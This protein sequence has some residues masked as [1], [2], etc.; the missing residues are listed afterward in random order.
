MET[1]KPGLML[2]G[3]ICL[4]LAA[5]IVGYN[6]PHTPPDPV[7]EWT[8]GKG[9]TVNG[10]HV[11]VDAL[12][13]KFEPPGPKKPDGK[14]K[15]GDVGDMGPAANLQRNIK[16]ENIVRNC[17]SSIDGSGLCVPACLE[18]MALSSGY[19]EM[20]GFVDHAKS[21]PGG[22]WPEKTRK[23]FDCFVAHKQGFG[24]V[25]FQ[26]VIKDA[27]ERG[28]RLDDIDKAFENHGLVMIAYDGQIPGHYNNHRVCTALIINGYHRGTGLYSCMDTNYPE[29]TMSIDFDMVKAGTEWYAYFTSLNP[30][31]AP[32]AY[33]IVDQDP[34]QLNGPHMVNVIAKLD[35][36][37]KTCP[38]SPSCDCG[39]CACHLMKPAAF[40][41]VEQRGGGPKSPEL[42][43][44][45][46][47]VSILKDFKE[48]I[49][50]SNGKPGLRDDIAGGL[51]DFNKSLETRLIV[52][53][54]VVGCWMLW[55]GVSLHK[56][57]NKA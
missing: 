16:R 10:K 24:G 47:L 35:E 57:A 36:K 50:G 37:Q 15:S 55:V 43:G 6:L 25:S 39:S 54:G 17:G 28:F 32:T 12:R 11:D 8:L 40:Q 19:S 21:L 34:L 27:K 2:L 20:K 46:S 31:S 3:V 38:C 5:G 56:L 33:L 23:Q 52:V 30:P 53:G 1:K 22:H 14:K 44:I 42:F 18:T 45:E 13:L 26:L 41:S 29:K 49:F 51:K 48:A 4:A 9:L 7:I